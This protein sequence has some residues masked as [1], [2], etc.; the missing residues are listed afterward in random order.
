[1]KGKRSNRTIRALVALCV[2][3]FSALTPLSVRAG[4]F[5][6]DP[7]ASTEPAAGAAPTVDRTPACDPSTAAASDVTLS[8]TGG[9]AA[10]AEMACRALSKAVRFWR[11]FAPAGTPPAPKTVHVRFMDRLPVPGLA[12]YEVATRTVMARQD[13]RASM[14]AH[15]LFGLP[16]TEELAT[17]ILVHEISH[18]L[19]E[20]LYSSLDGVG[21]EDEY[22][23]CV[24]QIHTLGGSER[25]QVQERVTRAPL[26]EERAFDTLSYELHRHAFG[27]MAYRHFQSEGGGALFLGRIFSRS[28]VAPRQ[29]LF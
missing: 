9:T 25:E 20:R 15:R 27:M 5:D 8:V 2:S 16:M 11:A 6:N 23:A 3:T 29:D 14:V 21:V 19:T 7:I 26:P 4:E 10:D 13:M 18:S 12:L 1:M 28:F 17:S 22:A 24:A